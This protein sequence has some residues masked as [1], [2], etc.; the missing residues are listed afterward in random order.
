MDRCLL[1]ASGTW[2]LKATAAD[3]EVPWKELESVSVSPLT[4]KALAGGQLQIN[5]TVL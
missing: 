4:I 3:K 5:F 1:Q 2:Y